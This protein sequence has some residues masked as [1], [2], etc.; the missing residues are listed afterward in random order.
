MSLSRREARCRLQLA[1][2]GSRPVAAEGGAGVEDAEEEEDEEED[3]EAAAEVRSGRGRRGP[4]CGCGQSAETG[5]GS[6]A[7]TVGCC[8]VRRTRV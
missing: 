4:K 2:T 8:G 6:G 5:Q 7:T 3:G 1:R